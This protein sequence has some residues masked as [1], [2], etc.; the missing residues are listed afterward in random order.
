M[1][2]CKEAVCL[3]DG[4]CGLANREDGFELAIEFDKVE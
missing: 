1:D 3:A 2:S 4:S